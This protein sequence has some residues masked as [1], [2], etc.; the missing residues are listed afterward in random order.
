MRVRRDLFGQALCPL[1]VP[2]NHVAL[3]HAASLHVRGGR[4]PSI[5]GTRRQTYD[6]WA[7]RSA[8]SKRT[9]Q[10]E[11]SPVLGPT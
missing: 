4:D 6:A 3:D 11:S 1:R 2:G 10:Q 7:R 8:S 9:L 5:V